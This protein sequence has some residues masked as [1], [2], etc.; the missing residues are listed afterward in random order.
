[1]T[2]ALDIYTSCSSIEISF[3]LIDSAAGS[4]EERIKEGKECVFIGMGEL[5]CAA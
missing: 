4:Q 5:L 2:C 3:K 1:M